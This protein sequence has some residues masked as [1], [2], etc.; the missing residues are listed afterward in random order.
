MN[1]KSFVLAC[2]VAVAL[3]GPLA[4]GENLFEVY[5]AAVKNDPVIREAEAR[6]LAALEVKP[7][8]RGLLFPQ[9]GINGQYATSS[10]ESESV[11]NQAV[12]DDGDPNTPPVIAIVNNNQSSDSDYWQYQAELTQTIFRW[13]Q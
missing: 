10:D 11:F 5:Q 6:R 4:Q 8:A 13:D 2:S 3:F 12:D 7:Q 9:I 1:K